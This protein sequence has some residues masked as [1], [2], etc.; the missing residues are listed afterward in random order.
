MI[1]ADWL[2]VLAFLPKLVNIMYYEMYL[3]S[4]ED[5]WQAGEEADD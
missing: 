1:A 3:G 4:N 2:S 5:H